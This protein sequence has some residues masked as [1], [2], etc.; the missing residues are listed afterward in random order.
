VQLLRIYQ[1]LSDETRLRI[2]HL[3]SHRPLCV[4]HLQRILGAPQVKISKH[5]T[6]LKRNGLVESKAHKNWRIYQL[7]ANSPY[8][9]QRHLE[10]LRDCARNANLFPEDL[11]QLQ[12]L[13]PELANLEAQPQRPRKPQPAEE[14]E[15]LPSGSL[16]ERLL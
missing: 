14:E 2:L 13:E 7:P 16:E 15:P 12:A 6:F 4:S 1:S 9:L 11:A 5:L 8:E 10:S 3:L